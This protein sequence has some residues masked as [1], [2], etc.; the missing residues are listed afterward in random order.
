M[1]TFTSEFPIS[2][3]ITSLFSASS[4]VARATGAID[5]S[6]Q[7]RRRRRR[8]RKLQSAPS[9]R[10][11]ETFAAA[12]EQQVS[13]PTPTSRAVIRRA[14][15]SARVIEALSFSRRG[16]GRPPELRVR[17]EGGSFGS[18][19]VSTA[20]DCF[21][22]LTRCTLLVPRETTDPLFNGL[23][24]Y[25]KCALSKSSELKFFPIKLNNLQSPFKYFQTRNVS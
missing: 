11:R 2:D 1:K 14:D 7:S 17:G 4:L 20:E 9:S 5:S 24:Y 8:H 10:P 23:F 21:W 12:R 22:Y 25:A 15:V 3:R 19:S 6:I 16:L 13:T 18:G